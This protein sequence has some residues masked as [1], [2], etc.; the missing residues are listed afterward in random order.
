ME[1][2]RSLITIRAIAQWDPESGGAWERPEHKYTA[3]GSKRGREDD[4]KKIAFLYSD[5]SRAYF[6]APAKEDK[7]VQLPGEDWKIGD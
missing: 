7:Y 2:F 4:D 6:H 3:R 5:I 1:L